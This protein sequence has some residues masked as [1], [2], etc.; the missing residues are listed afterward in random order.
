MATRRASSLGTT[1]RVGGGGGG[2]SPMLARKGS[3]GARGAA[4]SSSPV[5]RRRVGG[6][7]GIELECELNLKVDANHSSQVSLRNPYIASRSHHK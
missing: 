2:G 5:E 7:L 1:A 6:A 4:P 3:N